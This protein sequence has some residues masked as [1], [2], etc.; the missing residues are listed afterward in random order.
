MKEFEMLE[1]NTQCKQGTFLPDW[2][3]CKR[4]SE[5][6]GYQMFDNKEFNFELV[7]RGCYLYPPQK[8]FDFNNHPHGGTR[9][10]CKPVCFSKGGH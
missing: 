10:E 5:E 2:S 4:A 3:T 1:G 7:P 8:R 6:M 9:P